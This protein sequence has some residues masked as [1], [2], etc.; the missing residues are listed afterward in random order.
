[1][2]RI[3][4]NRKYSHT[5]RGNV[6]TPLTWMT[7]I[8]SGVVL[9]SASLNVNNW[10]GSC[11]FA[12]AVLIIIFYG[13][14]YIYYTIKDPDRLQSEHFNLESQEIRLKLRGNEKPEIINGSPKIVT[15]TDDQTT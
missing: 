14:M 5:W 13:A 10:L 3:S 11:S 7:T 12:L 6:M 1:M 15:I 2:K 4:G 8:A 9:T